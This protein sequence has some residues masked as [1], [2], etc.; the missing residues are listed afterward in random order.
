M[1]DNE[2]RKTEPLEINLKASF[3]G[4]S[5]QELIKFSGQMGRRAHNDVVASLNTARRVL[6]P[7]ANDSPLDGRERYVFLRHVEDFRR[8]ADFLE[9]LI[10]EPSDA[11]SEL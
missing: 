6:Y 8:I 3:Q 5:A 1:D 4:M 11:E 10:Q 9:S 2:T 7:D